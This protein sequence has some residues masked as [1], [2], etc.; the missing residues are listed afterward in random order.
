MEAVGK[1]TPRENLAD[2]E[3]SI[4]LYSRGFSSFFD[5]LLNLKDFSLR[6]IRSILVALLFFRGKFPIY[7]LFVLES[8]K[9]LQLLRYPKR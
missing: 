4:V 3:V 5:R 7:R 1:R 6:R 2:V 9:I 8:C